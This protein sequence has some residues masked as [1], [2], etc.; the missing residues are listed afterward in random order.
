MAQLTPWL[1]QKFYETDGVTP[2]SG[3]LIFTYEAG[4]TTKK[5]SYQSE[6][7]SAN[8]NPIVADAN[9]EVNLWFDSGPYKVVYAPA[10]DTDPPTSPVKTWDNINTTGSEGNNG[11]VNTYAELTALDEGEYSTVTVLGAVTAG[12]NGAGMF[13]WDAT[14]TATANGGTIFTPDT[15]DGVGRWIR[16]YEGDSNV[17]WWSVVGDGVTDDTTNINTAIQAVSNTNLYFPTGSYLLTGSLTLKSGVNLIGVGEGSVLRPT[18]DILSAVD[19]ISHG[20]FSGSAV[21]NIVIRDMKVEGGGTWTATPFANPYGSGNV[22]GFTNADIGLRLSGACDNIQMINCEINGVHRIT[23]TGYTATGTSDTTRK[24][25]IRIENCRTETTG[26]GHTVFYVDGLDI[27]DCHVKSSLGNITGAGGTVSDSKFGD[28]IYL[29][30]CTQLDVGRNHIEDITRIGIV[31][32]GTGAGNNMII[33][34]NRVHNIHDSQDAEVNGCI[35]VEGANSA[36]PIVIADNICYDSEERG[37]QLN[38]SAIVTGGSVRNCANTGVT[39]FNFT[40]SNVEM[41]GCGYGFQIASGDT[42]SKTYIKNC[43]ISDND[44]G[45]GIIFR[46]EGLVEFKNNTVED[47]GSEKDTTVDGIEFNFGLKIDR[48]YNSQILVIE[49]NTFISSEDS[50]ATTGQLYAIMGKSGGDFT[51]STKDFLNNQ[52]RF[53]GTIDAYPTGLE[54]VPCSYGYN[55][56]STMSP[57][58]LIGYGG[59]INY[60]IPPIDVQNSSDAGYFRYMGVSPNTVP[61]TN[62]GVRGDYYENSSWATGRAIGWRLTVSGTPDT[63]ER[64]DNPVNSDGPF[65][66]ESIALNG[67]TASASYPVVVDG[68]VGSTSTVNSF[69]VGN[70]GDSNHERIYIYHD[71]STADIASIASGTGTL[72]D[73]RFRTGNDVWIT[74]G[75]NGIISITGNINYGTTSGITASTTQSQ[76]QAPLTTEINE[77]SDVA[78]ANDVV[79]LKTASAGIKQTIINNGANTLQIYPASGDDLGAGVNTSTTLASGSNVTYL[80]YDTTNWVSI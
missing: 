66:A 42:T 69:G 36:P 45:G 58:E 24:T 33:H 38:R 4:T 75:T 21:S 18:T 7:G 31:M 57:K 77:V 71:G 14:S 15:S 78:N 25:N 10:G 63:Y 2:A 3:A 9:G 41:V 64:V 34:D 55:N 47:N 39:G 48:F 59:N 22:V 27:V 73:I 76:G 60:K 40:M 20:Y 17:G 13:R 11:V 43:L 62:N 70:P 28:G 30:D 72:R 5:D 16:I 50:S 6:S 49:D 67:L 74:I 29:Y 61:V 80:A 32:E 12:D 52:F 51:N 56:T 79:T 35:W 8:T 54:V 26:R 65:Q 19:N 37:L 46:T 68:A 23:H 44:W 1:V 53:T